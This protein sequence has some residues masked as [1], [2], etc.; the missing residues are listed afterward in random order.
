METQ[1]TVVQRRPAQSWAAF[2]GADSGTVGS[3]PAGGLAGVDVGGGDALGGN[4]VLVAQAR[5]LGGEMV[6]AAIGVQSSTPAVE[7]G[8]FTWA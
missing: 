2:A 7:R 8:S 4:P 3:K 6:E 5:D 1:S